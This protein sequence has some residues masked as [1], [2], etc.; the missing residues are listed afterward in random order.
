MNALLD[1]PA[2]M[3]VDQMAAPQE[4]RTAV[5]V[6]ASNALDLKK[7]NLTDVALAQFG[8]WRTALAEAQA[9]IKG[10]AWN[11]ST[12]KGLADIK[13]V[14]QRESKEPRA[15]ANK[16]ADALASKLTKVSKEVRAEQAAIVAAWDKLAEPL[17]AI[18][19][20]REAE[21]AEEARK[22]AEAKAERE[23][24]E[25]EA[26]EA[27][28]ARLR[29]IRAYVA[30]CQAPGMTAERIA[31]GM[32]TLESFD[33][34]D[35]VPARAVELA[36]AQCRTLEDMRVMHAQATGREQ[37]AARQE[38]IRKEN[39][40]VA[41][42][43]AAER[44]RI[45]AELAEIRR[46]ADELAAQR[47]E[48]ERLEALAAASRE[49]LA[50]QAEEDRQKAEIDRAAANAFAALQDAKR[51]ES[52]PPQLI[53]SLGN[54]VAAIVAGDAI[55]RAQRI[56]EG[57]AAQQV[58]KAEGAS[59]DA[60]DRDVPAT[61]SPSV[62]SMGA[63]QLADAGPDV[64]DPILPDDPNAAPPMTV[65][66]MG[67]ETVDRDDALTQMEVAPRPVVD[68]FGAELRALIKEARAS[69]FPSHPKMGKE[70]WDR[71]F[72]LADSYAM[73]A[74]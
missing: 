17:T 42:E 64:D 23:R 6:A 5:A 74:A 71:L 26:L 49:R 10:I 48:S 29:T 50:R 54:A 67:A 19:D 57:Q 20:A 2:I 69:S 13:S 32:K 58:L 21:L 45:A 59:P 55:D 15:E 24:I 41:R 63:G 34:S 37:E 35:P 44:E 40:R 9:R 66:E 18:I 72:A 47:A 22:E 56:T 31:T 39:E 61:T 36:D 38:E 7:V 12:P 3:D 65:E 52:V 70:W 4:P 60:T 11:V 25:Q 33:V 27:F 53:E 62:G 68:A 73:D 51:E 16:I 30:H 43:L 8:D 28:N 1:F 14:R 46:Q